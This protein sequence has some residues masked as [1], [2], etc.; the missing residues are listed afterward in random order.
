MVSVLRDRPTERPTRHLYEARNARLRV[1]DTLECDLRA[2]RSVAWPIFWPIIP[3]R[4]AGRAEDSPARGCDMACRGEGTAR[5]RRE[6]GRDRRIAPA[7]LHSGLQ[8]QQRRPMFVI[9]ME[10]NNYS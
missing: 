10:K 4:V 7:A 2:A 8:E 6:T 1:V 9:T 3:S 5:R